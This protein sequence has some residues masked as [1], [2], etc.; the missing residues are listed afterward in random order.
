MSIRARLTIAIAIVVLATVAV[1]STVVVQTTRATLIGQVDE[2]VLAFADRAKGKPDPDKKPED[3]HG[4]SNSYV[5]SD[6]PPEAGDRNDDWERND[7]ARV[8]YA[9]DGVVLDDD[10]YGYPDDRK[11][12]PDCPDIPSPELDE[13][14]G[15]VVTLPSTDGTLSYR[16]LIQRVDGGNL[17][18]VGAPLTDVND[19]VSDLV[20]AV[21]VA[22][23]VALLVATA[24]CWWVIRQGLKP[25]DH[26]VATAAAIAGGNLGARIERPDPA[27]EL[28]RLGSALN[29]MMSKIQ[30][31]DDARTAGEV[32][33]R[34][35]VADAAHELRTPLTS[36]RGYAELYRQGALGDDASV[37]NAM[38]RIESE[39]A[40]MARLVDDLLLLARLDQDRGLERS[41]VDLGTLVGDAVEDFRV[42]TPDRSVTLAVEPGTTVLG[43]RLRLRQIV[44]NLLANVR[45]HTPPG[46]E[47]RISVA[48]DGG[49]AVLTVADTGP[50]IA[51]ED[52]ERIF[53][54]F[55]RADPARTRSRGGTGL[56]LAIVVSLV[57]A[58]SGSIAI[59]S[60]V[61][62][63]ASFIVKLPLTPAVA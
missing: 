8:V 60:A 29:D 45:I 31:A 25:V 9:P 47:V 1:L 11:A 34:R 2:Q 48:R 46:T 51:R 55:W 21:L 49:E 17:L 18:A 53:E 56:G 39:G 54:R 50:G 15:E 4:S 38:G 23:V 41:P 58:H 35:F 3:Q 10:R 36:L 16:T 32:R 52:Q 59:E 7:F 5:V 33:L 30:V 19:A 26:M 27:T 61:G 37:T 43:D 28:G 57:E 42:V 24:L 62:E 63:G 6:P 13:I 44:D 40:R 22:S 12:L 20:R 14:L